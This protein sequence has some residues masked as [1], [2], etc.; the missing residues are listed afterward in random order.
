MKRYIYYCFVL[1]AILS[2]KKNQNDAFYD[3]LNDN[4]LVL[5]DTIAYDYHTFFLT[6]NDPVKQ[7]VFKDYKICV[8]KKIA[9]SDEYSSGVVSELKN[10]EYPEYLKL[11]NEKPKVKIE[12]IDLSRLKKTGKFEIVEFLNFKMS[13]AFRERYVGLIRLYQPYISDDYAILFYSKQSSQ[14]DGV[15]NA[16]LLKKI[17]NHW[18]IEK[19]IE[20]EIW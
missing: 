15:V 4:F 17:N 11:L 19:K 12:S 14:K 16:F 2:C 13:K 10:G 3:I 9:S 1:T 8:D 18:K 5:T 6:P 20:L 7:R